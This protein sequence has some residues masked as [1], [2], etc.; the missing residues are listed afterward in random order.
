MHTVIMFALLII[1]L[2]GIFFSIFATQNTSGVP[3]H[4]LGYWSGN[5]PLY[6]VSLLSLFT[7][8]VM[9]WILSIF[10]WASTFFTLHSKDSY[11]KKSEGK[12]DKLQQKISELEVE[13]ATLREEKQQI[14]VEAKDKIDEVK[15]K[16]SNPTVID[17]LRTSL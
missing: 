1:V 4:L 8:V 16:R 3:V 12:I 5:I 11:I 10:G 14:R 15:L 2:F 7:G 13:N 17:R 9:S 6:M